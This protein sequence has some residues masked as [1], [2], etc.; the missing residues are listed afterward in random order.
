MA[1]LTQPSRKILPAQG[2]N[3]PRSP[4]VFEGPG[5]ARVPA[6]EQTRFL[7]LLALASRRL[8]EAKSV[9]EHQQKLVQE[10]LDQGADTRDAEALLAKLKISAEAMTEHQR[11]IERQIREFEQGKP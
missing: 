5:K 1:V 8:V 7:E 6:L 2:N 10:L 3:G 9:I 11:T 4:F